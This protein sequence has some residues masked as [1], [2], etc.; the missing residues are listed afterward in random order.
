MSERR[1]AS[2]EA[3]DLYR[4]WAADAAYE[5]SDLTGISAGDFYRAL[6]ALPSRTA[7]S[8]EPHCSHFVNERQVPCPRMCPVQMWPR[9]RFRRRWWLFGPLVV[10]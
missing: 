2:Q 1:W 10:R 3:F 5:G 6:L 4:Q 8:T 9:S 7:R